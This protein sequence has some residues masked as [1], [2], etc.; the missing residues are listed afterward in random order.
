MVFTIKHREKLRLSQLL[1][2]LGS[3]FNYI[4]IQNKEYIN[5]FICNN[6]NN[7]EDITKYI[8]NI[9]SKTNLQSVDFYI[10]NFNLQFLFLSLSLRN[11]Y[12]ES[13]TNPKT[14]SHI[15]SA[16]I[17]IISIS[18]LEN[19]LQDKNEIIKFID[20]ITIQCTSNVC[21]VRGFAQFFI[22]KIFSSE[23]LAKKECILK[24]I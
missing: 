24:I 14:K 8:I 5:D 12:L 1:V 19:V 15:V 6:K 9:F 20:S 13:I 4:K 18:I 17:I 11:Y 2:T 3:I 21:N 22:D 7:I 16:C 23:E 10:Y